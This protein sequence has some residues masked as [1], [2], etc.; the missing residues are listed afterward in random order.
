MTTS[1]IAN[2]TGNLFCG[3]VMDLFTG[4]DLRVNYHLFWLT[5]VAGISLLLCAVPIW[6]GMRGKKGDKYQ[7]EN[8]ILMDGRAGSPPRVGSAS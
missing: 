2:F 5:P 1:G 8:E 3:F 6:V 4:P 7:E